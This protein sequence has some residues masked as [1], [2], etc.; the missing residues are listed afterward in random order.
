ME[1]SAEGYEPAKQAIVIFAGETL[2][3]PVQLARIQPPPTKGIL[4]LKVAPPEA[5]L[6][7]DGKLTGPANGFNQELFAGTHV[8][9]VSAEGYGETKQTVTIVTGETLPVRL[10][11]DPAPPPPTD[12]A[13]G[14]VAGTLAT[15]E[16]VKSP[17][18]APA[19]GTATADPAS[20]PTASPSE[21]A[22]ESHA[23]AASAQ[24]ETLRGASTATRLRLPQPSAKI[25]NAAELRSLLGQQSPARRRSPPQHQSR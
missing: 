13:S 11:L 23:K 7:L 22:A 3:V 15:P 21:S 17:P 25:L 2:R 9:E 24:V 18:I 4:M 6:T 8:I 19:L 5:I 14:A 12:P 10:R 16:P 1:I 20:Q